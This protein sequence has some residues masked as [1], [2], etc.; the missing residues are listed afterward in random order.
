MEVEITAFH[1]E[2]SCTKHIARHQVGGEL[3]PAELRVDELA[4]G[5]SHQ[6]LCHSGHALKQY[7]AVCEYRGQN[8]IYGEMLAY[9]NF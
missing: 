9:N 4:D 1:V 7:V 8:Q 6:R 3:N 5:A 2:H